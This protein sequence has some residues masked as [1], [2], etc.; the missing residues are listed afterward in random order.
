MYHC[1]YFHVVLD[2]CETMF[3]YDDTEMVRRFS[4]Y[5]SCFHGEILDA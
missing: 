5:C 2:Q 3:H 1:P 4:L